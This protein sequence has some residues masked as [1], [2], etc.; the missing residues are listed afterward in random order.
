AVIGSSVKTIDVGAFQSCS[1][2]TSIVIPGS[3]VT[4]S[5]NA[6]GYCS[7]LIS[8]A[9]ESL[10]SEDNFSQYDAFNGDLRAKYLAHGGGIGTYTRANGSSN[11]WTK[12]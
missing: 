11:T 5:S 7:A 3:V 2:L 8:V 10:I 9:F 1:K 6:F 12:K 4:I